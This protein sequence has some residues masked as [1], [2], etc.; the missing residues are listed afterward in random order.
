MTGSLLPTVSTNHQEQ[1]LRRHFLTSSPNPTSPSR[2]TENEH[3]ALPLWRLWYLIAALMFSALIDTY[4]PP[5][6]IFI[7]LVWSDSISGFFQWWELEIQHKLSSTIYLRV[8]VV[9]TVLLSLFNDDGTAKKAESTQ[10]SLHP[11]V[12]IWI[13]LSRWIHTVKVINTVGKMK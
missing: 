7:Q 9:S 1:L 8:H 4:T 6:S 11:G 3:H 13:H 10:G 12:E 2:S 5:P